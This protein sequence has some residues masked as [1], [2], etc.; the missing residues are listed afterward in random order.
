MVGVV[1]LDGYKGDGYYYYYYYNNDQKVLADVDDVQ[2]KLVQLGDVIYYYYCY[3]Y[4]ENGD[5]QLDGIV[6]NV[7]AD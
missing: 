6:Y 3:W 4:G 1:E 2:V 7:L 5:I